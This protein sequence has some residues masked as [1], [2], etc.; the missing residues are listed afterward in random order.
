MGKKNLFIHAEEIFLED[1]REKRRIHFDYEDTTL[2]VIINKQV[3][4]LK[5][6]AKMQFL[7]WKNGSVLH[8]CF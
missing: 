2:H 8:H 3:T 6:I 4:K 1:K 7:K 5:L